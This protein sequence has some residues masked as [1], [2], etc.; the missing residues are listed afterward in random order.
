MQTQLS[1]LY[2]S[3]KV[4]QVLCDRHQHTFSIDICLSAAEELPEG[5]V[6]FP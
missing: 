1:V 4:V 5:S 6:L 2:P 3:M